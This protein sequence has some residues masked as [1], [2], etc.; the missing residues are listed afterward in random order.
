M[1][2]TR[3]IASSSPVA[4]LKQN[5]NYEVAETDCESDQPSTESGPWH[6]DWTEG[7]KSLPSLQSWHEDIQ[8]S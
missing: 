6:Q 5:K 2:L 8:V 1:Q 7:F 3:N 4:I